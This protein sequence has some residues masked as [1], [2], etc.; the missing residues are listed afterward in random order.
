MSQEYHLYKD[1]ADRTGGE[2]YLGVVGGVRTGKSTLIRRFMESAVLPKITDQ[3]VKTRLM[4]ELPQAGSGKAVMTTE[5]KFIPQEAATIDL[6]DGVSVNIRMIDCVGY[7]VDGAGGHQENG[8]E[9]M[10]KTP[11]QEEEMPFSKAAEMG[12]RKVIGDHSTIGIVVTTD[13]S[14]TDIPRESYEQAE[15]RTIMEL[16]ASGKPFVVIFNTNKPY[17][18]QTQ[19]IVAQIREQYDTPCLALNCEQLHSEDVNHILEEILYAFPIARLDFYLPKW[20]DMLSVE[21]PVTQCLFQEAAKILEKVTHVR[22][23]RDLELAPAQPYMKEIRKG[24]LSLSDGVASIQMDVDEKYYY[25]NMSELTGV[26]IDGEYELI[27][28]VRDLSAKKR[29]LEKVYEAMRSVSAGGYGVVTPSLD[30]IELEEPQLVKHGGKYGV[31]LKARSM[32]VHMIRAAIETEIAPIVG[33]EGHAKDLI[34]Y[35]KDGSKNDGGVWNTNIFGKSIGELMED[36]IRSKIAKMDDECQQKLQDT[37]QKV[38]NDNKG[39]MVCII[40]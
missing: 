40:L 18:D 12:T 9:R 17:S 1:I 35:I 6:G 20:V 14:F 37:M 15:R 34:A 13:G 30:E 22:D 38:V 16:K 21:H 5:P 32:S 4:D 39:G 11:W 7:M 24:K 33:S 3:N 29:E 8:V 28:L 26:Q 19:Q 10:V 23:F 36:G 25:E 27:S 2:I 31:R